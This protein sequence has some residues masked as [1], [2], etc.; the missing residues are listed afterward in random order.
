MRRPGACQG[1]F[2]AYWTE[3]VDG[4]S[5]RMSELSAL[6]S[7]LQA[8]W[9]LGRLSSGRLPLASMAVSGFN[10]G[11]ASAV[12]CNFSRLIRTP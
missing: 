7:C 9:A 11:F 10:R 12:T 5:S 1:V 8:K 4:N 2:F 6:P 3:Q